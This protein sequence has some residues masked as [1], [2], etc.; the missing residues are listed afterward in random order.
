MK[1]LLVDDSLTMRRIQKTQLQKMN[2]NDVLEAENGA[3]AYKILESNMPMDLVFLDWNMPVMDGI[4]FLKKVRAEDKYK[5][6]KII[7]C[8]S[9][10]EKTKV[11]EAIKSGANDYMVKPFTPQALKEK[12]GL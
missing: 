5:N 12:L 4:S 10:S 3:D 6:V 1:I 9:E 2:L 7:M 8:T 11:I